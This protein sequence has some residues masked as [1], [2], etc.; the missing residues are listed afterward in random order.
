MAIYS[1]ELLN[2]VVKLNIM[3]G[4]KTYLNVAYAEKDAAKALGARW[5]PD[6]K[7]WYVP[8]DKDVAQFTQWLLADAAANQELVESKGSHPQIS[9]E[10]KTGVFTYP[11]ADKNFVAYAGSAAPWD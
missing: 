7:K 8:P 2:T 4:I 11:A 10:A 1:N 5:D 3:T 6:K 9:A